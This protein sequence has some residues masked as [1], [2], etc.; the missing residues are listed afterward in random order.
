MAKRVE[1]RLNPRLR[2]LPEQQPRSLREQQPR[3]LRQQ[4]PGP[5]VLGKIGDEVALFLAA[6]EMRSRG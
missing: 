4:Q 6:A 3:T 2:S 5:V 1:T